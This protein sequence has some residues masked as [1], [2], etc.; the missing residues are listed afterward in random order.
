MTEPTESSFVMLKIKFI[1][2][3]AVAT[4]FI[5]NLTTGHISTE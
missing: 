5:S 3:P 2:A 4:V 1:A